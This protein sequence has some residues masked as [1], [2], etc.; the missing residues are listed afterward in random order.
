MAPRGL[1]RNT[2]S[3]AT[4]E[5]QGWYEDPFR[6][7]QARYFSGG[8]PTKLVRDGNVESY[9]EPPSEGAPG[10]GASASWGHAVSVTLK[11]AEAIEATA[12]DPH[13]DDLPVYARRRPRPGALTAV[14]VVAIAGVATAVI[15]NK[16]RP[17]TA[18]VTEAMAYSATMN[19]SSADVYQTFA[20]TD[21]SHKLDVTASE[22]GPVSWSADQ[23]ELAEQVTLGGR[24]LITMRQLIDGTNNYSKISTKGLPASTL[25]G[26]PGLAG[27]TETTWTGAWSKDTSGFLPT[28]FFGSVSNPAQMASPS[29]LLGLLNAQASSVQNL[30]GD[31]LD[32][33]STT[34]YRALIPLSRLG[35]GTAEEE[36]QAQQAL[37]TSFIGVDYWIDSS[38]LLR[39]LRVAITVLHQ[40]SDATSSPGEVTVPL[41]TYPITFS[42]SL[43]LSHYGT[44]VHVVPPPAAQITSHVACV[45]S[46][47]GF[48]CTN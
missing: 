22:S 11:R 30:G 6:L 34:H 5:P 7:H 13:G 37:G 26:L 32:G 36:I 40:P 47:N 23:A 38:H 35:S 44:P 9:D 3:V 4:A 12:P 48:N 18:S 41:G 17:A 14:A 27:W 10:S 43:R 28:L 19:A 39:Q 25:T 46:N 24:Q 29:S 2:S 8:R 16:P 33:V 15:A 45:L 1:P 21:S 42:I 20:I 31:V